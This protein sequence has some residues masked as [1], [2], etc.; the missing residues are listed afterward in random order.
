MNKFQ[1]WEFTI[2][3]VTYPQNGIAP[4]RPVNVGVRSFGDNEELA[5]IRAKVSLRRNGYTEAD[6]E[7]MISRA[8][9]RRE[10]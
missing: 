5:R 8:T 3:N 2:R 10:D 1:W 4:E 9:V 6:A 7:E